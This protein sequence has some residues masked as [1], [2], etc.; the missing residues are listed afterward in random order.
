[1][2]R[3]RIPGISFSLKRALGLTA[4]RQKV[5][6]A[7]GVPTTRSGIERKI[8]RSILNALF[9]KNNGPYQTKMHRLGGSSPSL[10]FYARN[11]PIPPNAHY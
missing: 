9:K 1:M 7:L 11:L 6:K 8:G 5:S 4:L 10:H 2:A 3:W